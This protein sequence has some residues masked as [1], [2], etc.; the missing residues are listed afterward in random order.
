MKFL[1]EILL[2]FMEAAIF[3]E[4]LLIFHIA[5]EVTKLSLYHS[6]LKR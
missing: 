6:F 3:E 4:T 1:W 5:R 2:G